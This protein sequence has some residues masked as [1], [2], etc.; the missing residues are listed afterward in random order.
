MCRAVGVAAA[1]VVVVV[2]VDV[3]CRG[4]VEVVQERTAAAQRVSNGTA[5]AAAATTR[6]ATS[7]QRARGGRQTHRGDGDGLD[8]ADSSGTSCVDVAA[9][10]SGPPQ[11]EHQD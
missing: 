2:T 1:P 6:A 3:S 11:Y 8:A 5:A 7:D 4:R 10:P 9:T